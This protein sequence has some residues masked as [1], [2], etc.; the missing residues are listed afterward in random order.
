LNTKLAKLENNIL[1]QLEFNVS[2]SKNPVIVQKPT[3]K[4]FETNDSVSKKF[5]KVKSTNLI[6][7]EKKSSDGPQTNGK[8]RL[9][10]NVWS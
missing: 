6:K 9:M 1:K 4:T 7:D 5:S 8:K 2:V 3:E 10:L